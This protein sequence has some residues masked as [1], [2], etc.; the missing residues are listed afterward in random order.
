MT[1]SALKKITFIGDLTVDRPLLAYS[2]LGQNKFCFDKV[3]DQVR[4]NF[5]NTD[6]VIGN[7][8]TTLGG[9][10]NYFKTE[11]MLLNTPDEFA[12]AIAKGNIDLVTT[13]NNHTL[14]QNVAGLIRT[15]DVLDQNSIRH[16]GTY[17]NSQE[18]EQI[19]IEQLGDIKVAFVSR[20]YG[21]NETN[22]DFRFTKNN[23]FHIDVMKSQE[24]RFSNNLKGKIKKLGLFLFSPRLQRKIRRI[25]AG[26]KIKKS[27]V[28]FT[29]FTDSVKEND[30]E[31]FYYERWLE[32]IEK[33]KQSAD[34]VFVLPHMGGQFNTAPG[35]YSEKMMQKLLDMD[36]YVIANHPH[37]IQKV[38][39]KNNKL[40][41]FSVGSFNMSLSGDYVLKENLPQHSLGIHF[42]FDDKKCVR[43]SYSI[44]KI[45]EASDGG[46]QVFPITK[47]YPLLDQR[48]Q[49]KLRE[50]V[51]SLHQRIGLGQKG[52]E[53]EY[54]IEALL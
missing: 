29:A 2:H 22:I 23:S 40:G 47:R 31:N 18:Y 16:T 38:I 45:V 26:R 24:I 48:E 49:E 13:A 53:E 42:Y 8:E 11:Y 28:F 12:E 52:I 46:M 34:Y 21:I 9:S 4:D 35:T 15:L 27:G 50:E 36:V 6:L 37:I 7:F 54:P 39:V 33:A 32:K 10:D 30:F 5:A 41:A 14:D 19:L 51:N 17:R 25:I 3:F 44:Y 1:K 20:T 43:S